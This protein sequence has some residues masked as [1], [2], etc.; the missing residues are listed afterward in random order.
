MRG[1]TVSLA[2]AA[3]VGLSPA[4]ARGPDAA[5]APVLWTEP[6]DIAHRDLLHGPGGEA[7]GPQPPLRY[8][9]AELGGTAAKLR[10][11]DRAGTLWIAK[12]GVEARPEVAASRLLWAVGYAS[13]ASYYFRELPAAEVPQAVAA[14]GV[15]HE[16]RLEQARDPQLRSDTWRWRENPFVG[17]REFDGLRVMMALMNNW[18]L[19]TDNNVVYERIQA[20]VAVAVYEVADLGATFGSDGYVWPESE[21]KGNLAAYRTSRFIRRLTPAAVDFAS[22]SLPPLPYLFDFPTWVRRLR[23]PAVGRGIPRA[24]ARW[25]G[26]WLDRLT[27]AQLGDAFRAGGFSPGEV[28]GYVAVL[29]GRITR[30]VSL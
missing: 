5:L 24:H 20:G 15:L 18:D 27:L 21:A 9:P 22:P 14:D 29:R 19:K 3:A 26:E 16:V 4:L 8:V 11:R 30:L 1:F 10:L 7:G 25:I 23:M 13:D 6:A 28:E 17:T 12:L 2:V